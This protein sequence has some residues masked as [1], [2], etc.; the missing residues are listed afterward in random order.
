MDDG[1]IRSRLKAEQEERANF[2]EQLK[3]APWDLD[4]VGYEE[5]SPLV[6][7]LMDASEVV[8][9]SD[10]RQVVAANRALIDGLVERLSAI[11]ALPGIASALKGR[12]P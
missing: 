12:K 6:G 7:G 1:A 8:T 4:L 5:L 10:L 2:K 11:E 9:D 3:R